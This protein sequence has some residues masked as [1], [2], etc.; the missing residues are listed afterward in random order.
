MSMIYHAAHRDPPYYN[1]NESPFVQAAIE[2]QE[3]L[4]LEAILWGFHHMQWAETISKLWAQHQVQRGGKT[5]ECKHPPELAVS[6]V[7]KALCD[8]FEALWNKWNEILH[9]PPELAFQS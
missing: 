1:G 9:S 6:L 8:L 2:C 5:P 4:G 3:S 7:T